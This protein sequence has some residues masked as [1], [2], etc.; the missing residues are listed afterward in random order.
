MNSDD[1]I[2]REKAKIKSLKTSNNLDNPEKYA[3]LYL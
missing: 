2:I 1:S 3:S